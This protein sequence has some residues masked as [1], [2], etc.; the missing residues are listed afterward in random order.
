MPA[1]QQISPA[2]VVR[3]WWLADVLAPI[4]VGWGLVSGTLLV[5]DGLRLRRLY[6]AG[7]CGV[8]SD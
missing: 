8:G 6:R 4:T 3:L 2:A 7:L 5:A 1:A